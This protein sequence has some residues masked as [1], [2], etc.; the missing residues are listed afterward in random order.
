[1]S[2]DQR[3]TTV[4]PR[5]LTRQQCWLLA[6]LAPMFA[7]GVTAIA[8]P[9]SSE[10]SR[11]S[12][13]G[14][15]LALLLVG[16]TISDIHQRKIFNWMTYTALAWALLIN[17]VPVPGSIQSGA[18]GLF[19][20]LSGAAICFLVMLIPYSMARGG[21]GDVKLAT[22]IGAMV[23]IGDGLLIIA[24]TYIVAAILILGWTVWS[25][26]PMTLLSAMIRNVAVRL[27]PGHVQPLPERQ[28]ALL[29]QPIPLAGFFLIATMLIVFDI[30]GGLRS[31]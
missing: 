4:F 13:S 30:P 3:T 26:G 25:Q 5:K 24:F 14:L 18:I 6:A 10:T 20:S 29:N 27:F 8:V 28:H 7:L 19:N 12:V 1:M 9:E 21:A 23:G 15:L 16:A 11:L 22:A 17:T 2:T 31:F